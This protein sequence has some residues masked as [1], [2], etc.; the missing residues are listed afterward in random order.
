MLESTQTARLAVIGQISED[1]K[2]VR[3]PQDA[4]LGP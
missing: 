1:L 4:L 3:C 2:G